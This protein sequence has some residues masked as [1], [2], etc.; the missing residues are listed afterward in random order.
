[1]TPGSEAWIGGGWAADALG[2]QQ[3]RPHRDL[4][5]AV[6]AS[7]LDEAISRLGRLGYARAR[8]LLPVRLVM[9]GVD[10]R[11]VDLHPVTFD[12]SGHGRRPSDDGRVFEYPA[13]AFDHGTID[14]VVVPCLGAAQLVRFHHGYEPQEHDRQDMAILRERLGVD[15][16]PPY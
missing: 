1:M 10:G 6:D 9:N 2:G 5:L 14:T 12:L 16:P 15:V 11:S 8:D 13:D 3:M 7:D 4:D